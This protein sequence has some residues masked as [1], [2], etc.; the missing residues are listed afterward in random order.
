MGIGG[1]INFPDGPRLARSASQGTVHT[2]T[3]R[4]KTIPTLQY[5]RSMLIT[6]LPLEANVH[7]LHEAISPHDACFLIRV[8]VERPCTSRMSGLGGLHDR[9]QAQLICYH[10]FNSQRRYLLR[11]CVLCSYFEKI[12]PSPS[13]R[14][15]VVLELHF[16]SSGSIVLMHLGILSSTRQISDYVLVLRKTLVKIAVFC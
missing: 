11:C 6:F 4:A 14:P 5:F 15:D 10:P 12:Y 13:R 1:K 16:I 8:R 9:H 2:L 3:L 7:L